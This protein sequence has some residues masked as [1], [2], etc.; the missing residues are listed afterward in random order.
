MKDKKVVVTGGC[1][2][3]GSNLA[4]ELSRHN[5]MIIIDHLSTGKITNIENLLQKDNVKFIKGS[6]TNLDLL[7]NIFEDIDYVFHQAAIP[8][9]P[10]S[11]KNPLRTNNAN[12][13][14]TL[15][16]LV[17]ARDNHIKRLAYASSSSVYGDTPTLPEKESMTP[18]PLSHYVIT[19]LTGEY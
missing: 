2:F 13:D 19:K 6:I 14:G 12:I 15:N 7:Q 4:Q 8:S 9:V 11:V 1:G 17:A 3:I 16:V 10:G 5:E 18:T